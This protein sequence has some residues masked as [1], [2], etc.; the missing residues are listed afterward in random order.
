MPLRLLTSHYVYDTYVS[1]KISDIKRVSR[2]DCPSFIFITDTHWGDNRK[3]SADVVRRLL[4][5]TD[6]KRV[7]FGGDFETHVE[8]T[9]ADVIK[10]GKDFMKS[11]AFVQNGFYCAYGN[12]DNNS[13]E[14]SRNSEVLSENEVAEILVTRHENDTY[15]QCTPFTYYFDVIEE[16]SRYIVVNTGKRNLTAEEY[17]FIAKALN[18][19]G[20][21]Y[22]I[23]VIG[24]IWL[25]WNGI[26]HVP[27]Q[28]TM[29]LIGMFDAFNMSHP[30]KQYDFTKPHG[31]ITLILGGHVHYDR[32]KYTGSGVPIITCNADCDDKACGC[33][34]YRYHPKEQCITVFCFNGEENI[35]IIRIGKESYNGLIKEIKK[36]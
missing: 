33:K 15:T 13:Y 26:D 29:Q 30:W 34:H 25:E 27:N 12:H 21:T 24:H 23:I 36:R 2:S 3:K 35:N 31:H 22:K 11:F 6:I 7:F 19:T 4:S 14:Q 5:E 20:E 32:L 1:H 17:D 10:V 9:K 18:S 28:E 16:G 8:Q